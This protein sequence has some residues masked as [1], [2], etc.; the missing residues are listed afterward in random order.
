MYV[1]VKMLNGE[2][3]IAAPGEA[4]SRVVVSCWTKPT[5]PDLTPR[6]P[7]SPLSPWQHLKAVQNKKQGKQFASNYVRTDLVE[8][9]VQHC[10][11]YCSVCSF[12]WCLMS[13]HQQQRRRQNNNNKHAAYVSWLLKTSGQFQ[14]LLLSL[15][16]VSQQPDPDCQII[17]SMLSDEKEDE[18]WAVCV[19]D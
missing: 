7:L 3:T 10:V 15:L 8:S 2:V 1:A 16:L 9:V 11:R 6:P 19:S 4:A 14:T 18:N 13:Q 17:V 12:E 5:W